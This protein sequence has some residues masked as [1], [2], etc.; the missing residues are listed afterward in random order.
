VLA[1]PARHD[2]FADEFFAAERSHFAA[3]PAR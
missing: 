3:A 2:G 1:F